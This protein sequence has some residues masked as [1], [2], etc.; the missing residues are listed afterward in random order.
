MTNLQNVYKML[1]LSGLGGLRAS[2]LEASGLHDTNLNTL[3]TQ[4]PRGQQLLGYI[5][6]KSGKLI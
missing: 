3:S 6:K 5:L 1:S 4:T 2:S